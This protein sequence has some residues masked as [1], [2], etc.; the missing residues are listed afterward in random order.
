MS[1][2]HATQSIVFSYGSM[3]MEVYRSEIIYLIHALKHSQ[4]GG[5]KELSKT[6]NFLNLS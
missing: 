6:S 3:H 2:V 1:I 4:K 5:K